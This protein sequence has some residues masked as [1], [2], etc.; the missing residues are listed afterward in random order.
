MASS[1]LV[2]EDDSVIRELVKATLLSEGYDVSDASSVPAA[3]AMLERSGFDLVILDLMLG[4]ETGWDVV[5]NLDHSGR[6][7][8]TR[9]LVLS[10]RASEADILDGWERGVDGYLTK[11]FAVEDLVEA[12]E[13]VLSATDEELAERR[14]RETHRAKYLGVVED[15]LAGWPDR[16][17]PADG[18]G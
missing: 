16:K 9:L 12:V 2:I 1:I 13:D 7:S 8:Q 17:W 15:V 4:R 11:P 10:A 14:R 6:R 18:R 5:K 3:A